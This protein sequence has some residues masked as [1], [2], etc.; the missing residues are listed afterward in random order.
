MVTW[1]QHLDDS[2]C[3]IQT[4]HLTSWVPPESPERKSAGPSTSPIPKT[5]N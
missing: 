4:N 2:F 5:K 3:L 1:M